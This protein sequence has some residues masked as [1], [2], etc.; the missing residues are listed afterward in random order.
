MTY[1]KLDDRYAMNAKVIAVGAEAAFYHVAAIC[2]CSQNESDGFIP[3][4]RI[5]YLAPAMVGAKKAKRLV[6]A[7]VDAG[8]LDVV[9]GGYVAHDYLEYNTP[10]AEI[11]AKRAQVRERVQRHRT[12][13]EGNAVSNAL[14]ERVTNALVTHPETE[15]ETETE[16]PQAAVAAPRARAAATVRLLDAETTEHG[17]AKAIKAWESVGGGTSQYMC[18][19]LISL[20]EQYGADH[21]VEAI[22][23]AANSN[24]NGG[25]PS[26]NLVVTI[27]QR[28]RTEGRKPGEKKQSGGSNAGA[29]ANDRD[30]LVSAWKTS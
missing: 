7:L 27:A 30:A 3:D 19:R 22:G 20:V 5:F 12:K 11:D 16:T 10:K 17:N 28:S 14:P 23:E 24:R 1:A 9:E 26:M 18:E 8:L 25:T 4:A 15:T 2:D 13:R 6:A 21:I 29:Q